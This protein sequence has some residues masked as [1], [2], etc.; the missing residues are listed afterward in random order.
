MADEVKIVN[1]KV[2]PLAVQQEQL[3]TLKSIESLL[4]IGTMETMSSSGRKGG[5]KFSSVPDN[6]SSMRSFARSG[7]GSSI[8]KES[9]VNSPEF[10]DFRKGVLKGMLGPLNLIIDPLEKH[11]GIN[12]GKGLKKVSSGLLTTITGISEEERKFNKKKKDDLKLK[13]KQLD[14]EEK[15]T[16]KLL[17]KMGISRDASI[18]NSKGQYMSKNNMTGLDI[19]KNLLAMNFENLSDFN[20]QKY[21]N[22]EGERFKGKKDKN[23]AF[24]GGAL[25]EVDFLKAQQNPKFLDW[26]GKKSTRVN[27]HPSI[28]DLA[29]TDVGQAQ[30]WLFDQQKNKDKKGGF[31]EGMG[32]FLKGILGSAGGLLTGMFSTIL[33][34][35]P[36]LAIIG[37]LIMMVM[38]GFK[39]LLLSKKWGVNKISGAIGGFLAG[40]QSGIKGAFSNMGKWAIMGAGIGTLA[41][42]IPIVG[43]LI[44]G[45][46]GAAVGGILGFIGGQKVAQGVDF[47]T[48]MMK[49]FI[50]NLSGLAK[51]G[52][53]A[54]IP[55]G[56]AGMISGMLLGMGIDAIGSLIVGKQNM[57]KFDNIVS[58]FI[59][60]IANWVSDT[61]GFFIFKL[62][63]MGSKITQEE[64]NTNEQTKRMDKQKKEQDV[65]LKSPDA[66][67]MS[68]ADRQSKLDQIASNYGNAKGGIA[69]QS[70]FYH[71]AEGN[72]P[73]AI[74]PLKA[75]GFDNANVSTALQSI[76]KQT[77]G[78]NYSKQIVEAINKLHDMMKNKP[79]NNVVNNVDSKFD[80]NTLRMSLSPRGA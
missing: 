63:H 71:L 36:F 77:N 48:K 5:K 11:L 8:D 45:L 38:D 33:K 26:F 64:F 75:E 73:E 50:G 1:R 21:S 55:L 3:T 66:K 12:F 42:P 7:F 39:G 29:K 56:P 23:L 72:R 13:Y 40:N 4:E 67:K 30:I 80:M 54:G 76:N 70:G 61:V 37:S 27:V 53:L 62:S 25:S 32:G 15:E 34:A 43:T 47:V 28:N 41:I 60:K 17:A 16:S 52:A 46:I 24:K 6:A 57:G 44:G 68:E 79:F 19:N 20:K 74:V 49:G 10:K 65:F 18:R 51:I 9:W 22:L 14:N 2:D 31:L 78:D 35:A 69:A 58:S 59:A